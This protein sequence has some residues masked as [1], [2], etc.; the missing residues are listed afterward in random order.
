LIVWSE[1]IIA[2]TSFYFIY[3]LHPPGVTAEEVS[4]VSGNSMLGI[5]LLLLAF[6]M[7]FTSQI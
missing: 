3:Y 2:A 6:P 7:V 4:P 5:L 1:E